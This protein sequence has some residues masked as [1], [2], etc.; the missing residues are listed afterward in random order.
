MGIVFYAQRAE[1][2]RR[3]PA[4][5]LRSARKTFATRLRQCRVEEAGIKLVIKLT[6]FD[7]RLNVPNICSVPEVHMPQLVLLMDVLYLSSLDVVFF[8]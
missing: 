4:G 5:I 6:L 1:D 8:L 2:Q 3:V 7:L